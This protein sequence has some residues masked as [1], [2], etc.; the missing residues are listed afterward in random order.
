MTADARALRTILIC[1]GMILTLSVGIRVGFGFF[2]RPMTMEFGWPRETFSFAMALHNLLWGASQPFL[3]AL[4]DRFG[5]PR[6]VVGSAITYAVG[7]ALMSVSSTGWMLSLSAGLIVGIAAAGTGFAIVIGVIGRAFPPE[8]RSNAI[9]ICAALGSFGQFFMA[10]V[11]QSLISALGWS[12]ALVALAAI[13]L[14]M[15]PLAIGLRGDRHAVAH[16]HGQTIAQALGE[17]GATP[18][19]WLLMGGYFVCGF[20]VA[21]V[22]T[23]LPAYLRDQGLPVAVSVAAMALIGLFNI[24]GSYASGRLGAVYTKKYLLAG[25]YFSRSV[26]I[27][28]FALLPLSAY[29]VYAFGMAFGL[30]YLST[31]PLT[32]G[33]IADIF[34]VRYLAMLSGLVFFSHQIGSF[35]GAWL[36]GRL[37]DLSGS[38]TVVWGMAIALGVI[39]ALF[40]LPIR[41]KAPARQAAA[42]V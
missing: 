23:H 1:G 29:S 25:V 34:G 40:N 3:G 42:A 24:F 5:A 28:L 14:A 15:V 35:F 19:F 41:E 12:G 4:A 33:L 38:Y 37:F 2:L 20:H 22:Q 11:E 36:G 26:V 18:S 16:H 39:A 10:P 7:L 9:G 21:F 32:N 17:A 30:L 8:Q 31:V 13:S 27:A 6:M